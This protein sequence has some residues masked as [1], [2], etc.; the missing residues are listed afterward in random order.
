MQKFSTNEEIVS[1]VIRFPK[2]LND[3]LEELKN[4]HRCSFQMEVINGLNK[5]LDVLDEE[6]HMNA[7]HTGLSDV[8]LA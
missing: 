8:E 4:K 5:Y 1:K 7:Q 3:R 6:A 2:S